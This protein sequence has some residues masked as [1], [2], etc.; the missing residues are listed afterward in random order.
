VYSGFKTPAGLS[1]NPAF[2]LSK[3]W[4][5]PHF[6]GADTAPDVPI[7]DGLEC[8]IIGAQRLEHYEAIDDPAQL[9]TMFDTARPRHD[10]G[11]G[12]AGLDS[13]GMVGWFINVPAFGAEQKDRIA[14]TALPQG[15]R[16]KP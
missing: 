9:N 11:S 13:P 6:I 3:H 4:G 14:A 7:L 10:Q 2:P 5:P 16:M 12:D 15:Q 8:R 1:L